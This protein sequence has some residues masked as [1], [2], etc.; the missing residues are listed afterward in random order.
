MTEMITSELWG[1]IDKPHA[2]SRLKYNKTKG[3]M[4]KT[5]VKG[6][7]DAGDKEQKTS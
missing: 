4:T 1:H 3:S 6:Q 5:A 2:L 7:P